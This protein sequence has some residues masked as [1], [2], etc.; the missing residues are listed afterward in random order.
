M[1]SGP[2]LKGDNK[3]AY[4]TEIS[5]YFGFAE[6]KEKCYGDRTERDF[7]HIRVYGKKTVSYTHL[8]L[9]TKA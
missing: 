9:P 5:D 2:F 4:R 3:N 6:R 7:R 1:A 8:T